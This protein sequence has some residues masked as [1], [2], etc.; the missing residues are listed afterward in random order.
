MFG[1][2]LMMPREHLLREVG[3][4]RN[5]LGYRELIGLK[6]LYRVSAAALLMR[7]RQL[8]VI[9]RIDARLRIPNDRARLAHPGARAT[10]DGRRRG[11]VGAAAALRAACAIALWPRVSISL[12]K[13]AELLRLPVPEVEA[14]LK[15]PQAGEDRRQ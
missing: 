2:A 9:T 13:A 8:E 1:G 15:G 6:R 7:L 11:P 14:G 3:K 10:R 5:A 12:T 4:H